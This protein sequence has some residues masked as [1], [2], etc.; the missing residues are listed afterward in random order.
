M[1]MDSQGFLRTEGDLMAKTL[2]SLLDVVIQ[3]EINAQKFYK[4]LSDKTHNPRLKD[5]FN[6]LAAEEE[7]HERILKGVKEMA[8]F[9]GSLEV[10]E[11]A[12]EKIEGAHVIKDTDAIEDLTMERAMEIAMKR[13]NKAARVYGEMA[14]SS[15]QE[16]IM[17]LF[18]S[19]AADE[20]RHFSTIEHHYRIHTGQMG[21]ED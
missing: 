14:A 5:F 1:L 13:E 10:D 20:R 3:D 7:G 2:N 6:T 17:K 19:I 9:D 4:I 11:E 18:T 12:M 16:E 21:R 8:L 15:P